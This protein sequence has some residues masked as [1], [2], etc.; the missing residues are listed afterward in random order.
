MPADNLSDLS[1]GYALVGHAVI[2]CAAGTLFER[3]PVEKGGIEP[4][5]RGPAIEPVTYISGNALF[6]RDADQA[7]HKAVIAVAVHRWR[8]PQYGCADT[9]C[10]QR[11][12]RLL[13]LAREVGIRRI[14]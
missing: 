10:R 13:R 6:P 1:S 5:H 3:E 7:R 11:K 14:L 8:K 2:A 4:V 12:R 9:A